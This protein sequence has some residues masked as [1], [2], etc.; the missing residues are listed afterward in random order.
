[1]SSP[2]TKSRRSFVL[3]LA[4]FIV[5]VVLAKLALE[6]QW[7][8]YGVTNQGKLSTAEYSLTDLNL[9]HPKFSEQWLLLYRVADNCEQRCQ[10]GLLAINNTYTLLGKELP[11]VTPVVISGGD[12]TSSHLISN[13]RHNKW[14]SL[15][16]TPQASQLIQQAQLLVVDPL[17]NVVM[18]HETP[19][20]E[21]DF[22]AFSKAILADMKKLLKYSRIG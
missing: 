22:S 1:M 13:M 6:Q 17:G 20:N 4:V 5:P 7:F 8:N 12:L 2:I 10:A 15:P 16:I 11:R 14:L 18:S 21:Q 9:A 19:E 3:L